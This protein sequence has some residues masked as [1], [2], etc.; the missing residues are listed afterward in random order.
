MFM[1]LEVNYEILNFLLFNWCHTDED[2]SIPTIIIPAARAIAAAA[3]TA[4]GCA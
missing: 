2:D 3:S 1:I 4:A